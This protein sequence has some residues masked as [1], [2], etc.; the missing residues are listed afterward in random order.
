MY[1]VVLMLPILSLKVIYLSPEILDWKMQRGKVI[2][3]NVSM[4]W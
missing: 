2:N 1:L 4:T 3:P